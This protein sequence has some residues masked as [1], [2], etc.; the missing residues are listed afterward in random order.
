M[1]N[2]FL[3]VYGLAAFSLSAAAAE[4]HLLYVAEPG[5]RN[6]LT[7]GGHGVVV[8]DIDHEHKFIRRIP[9]GG[10]DEKGVPRNVKG[11]CAHAATKRLFISTTHTLSCLD[12]VTDKVLWEK[13]FEGGCDRMSITQDGKDIYL[14]SFEKDFWNVVDAATG[15]IVKHLDTPNAGAH[16]TIVDAT[17]AHAY[18]AGLHSPM[19]RV[20]D[21]KTRE[22]TKE[23]GPFA[24]AIRP[25]TVNGKG[26]LCF[27]NINGLLGFEI[28][29]LT[30]G[31]KL[32]RVEVQGF[33]MGMVKRHGCPS[34]GIGLTPNEHE[35]WVTDG[36]NQ[37]MH[38]F[39]ATVMPPKQLGSI[40]VRDDPGWITFSIDGRFAYPSSGEVIDVTTHQILTTLEDE[41][42]HHVGSEKMLEIDFAGAEP[43]RNG[44]QFGLGR[45][46]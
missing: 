12:L 27:V 42:G 43:V 21:T 44:D 15:D 8:F 35:I 3:L 36:H 10:L 22:I 39:D 19:L 34:H 23:V 11:I 18:L 33:S 2:L 7:Y 9:F 30:T 25:Y 20:V 16:N 5:I 28:G 41:E 32:Y 31:Q 29:D 46:P 1:K 4:R 38:Y 24:S 45:V 6:D 17:G 26:T 40:P 14:P 37:R 13:P